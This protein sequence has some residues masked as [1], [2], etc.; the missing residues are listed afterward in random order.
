MKISQMFILQEGELPPLYQHVRENRLARIFPPGEVTA[1][2]N[3]GTSLAGYIVEVVSGVPFAEYIEENIY[4]PLGMKNSSFRQPLPENLATNISKPYRYV[5][6][7]FQEGKFEFMSKPAGSM[8]TTASDMAKFMLAYLQGGQLNGE[9]MLMKETVNKIFREP[10]TFYPLI[11]GMAHGFIKTTFNGRDTFHHGGG[12]MLYDTGFYLLP[13]EEIGFFISHSGGS[14][15]A[16]IE[17]FQRF[18]DRYLPQEE[19]RTLQAP[20]GMGK[21][22]KEF[23]G[24]YHQNRRILTTEDKFLSLLMGVMHVNVDDEGYLLVTHLGETNKFVEIEP[25]VY[26]NLREGRTHD[27]GGD[28]GTIVLSTDPMGKTMLMADGPMSYSMAA[29]YETSGINFIMLILSILFIVGSLLYWGVKGII[30]RLSK[31]RNHSKSNGIGEKRSKVIA[32]I[33][34][35]FTLIFV[36]GFMMEGA[37]DPVYGLPASAYS[38]PSPLTPLF[39]FVPYAMTLLSVAIVILTVVVWRKKY[40]RIAGRIHYILFAL[41]TMALTWIFYF[42]NV[43]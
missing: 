1:Y 5:D 41:A 2:S 18:M 4:R 29:W 21:R 15:L 25:G 13:E 30:I 7:E 19:V 8:S 42:W 3:Y 26:H 37:I 43:L 33:H 14:Y 10:F 23:I 20:E 24:E 12:T 11:N 32:I 39:D 38:K 6:G 22:V 35:L 31:K 27:Y 34:G 9:S 36:A 40:W 28:F 17:I 16:N